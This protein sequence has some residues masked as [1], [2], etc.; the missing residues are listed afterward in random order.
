MQTDNKALIGKKVQLK[1]G[2]QVMTV[3]GIEENGNLVVSWPA[4]DVILSR[5]VS[6]E[7]IHL[8]SL[9][10]MYLESIAKVCHQA[11]KAFCEASGDSSQKDWEKAEGWQKSSAINGVAFRLANPGAGEDSQHNSWMAEKLADGWVY[12]DVKDAVKKTHPCLVPFAELPAFQQKKDSL[13]CAIVD[14]LK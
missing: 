14:A 7:E 10:N 13:F 12:G 3:D 8:S 6:P 9:K 5:S 2:V 4:G 11:N 1:E